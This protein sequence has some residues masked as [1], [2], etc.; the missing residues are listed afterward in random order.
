[1]KRGFLLATLAFLAACSSPVDRYH[2]MRPAS[3]VPIN[4]ARAT[5]QVL[6]VGPVT[7]PD[8]LDREGWVVRTGDTTVHIYQHQ[9]WTQGLASEITQ[10]LADELN[11]TLATAAE[12]EVHAIWADGSPLNPAIDPTIV[13]PD[14]LRVRVQVLRF[15]SVLAPV[16]SISDALRW[17]LECTGSANPAEPALLQFHVLRSALREVTAPAQ[18]TSPGVA[19]D[20]TARRFDRLALAHGQALR[21]VAGD[22]AAAVAATAAER[23]RACPRR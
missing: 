19:D 1:M 15:D 7:I 4:S 16:P 21:A 10:T 2:T 17:T 13:A 3:A 8:S 11:R 12:P 6:T 18:A 5:E 9:L 23:A 22:I 20:D 14:A